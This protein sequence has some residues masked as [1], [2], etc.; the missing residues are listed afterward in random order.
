MFWKK[1]K[2][3]YMSR[4]RLKR[5]AR[6]MLRRNGLTAKVISGPVFMFTKIDATSTEECKEAI[7]DMLGIKGYGNYI[8][9][10][11][12]LIEWK[13]IQDFV[14]HTV[15]L[16][17]AVDHEIGH[18]IDCLNRSAKE[19][20]DAAAEHQTKIMLA[21]YGDLRKSQKAYETHPMEVA[22]NKIAAT[23]RR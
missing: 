10:P 6:T 3:E 13:E 19:V 7:H 4:G 21:G 11:Q 5:Y 22:A 17:Q 8:V 1:K 2:V 20:Y 9:V 12:S 23:L 15:P 16:T 18:L 14:G